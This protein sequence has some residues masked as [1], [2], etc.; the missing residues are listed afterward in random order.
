MGVGVGWHTGLMEA[1]LFRRVGLVGL[2]DAG[3]VSPGV[4]GWWVA[5]CMLTNPTQPTPKLRCFRAMRPSVCGPEWPPWLP[6]G[7]RDPQGSTVSRM[8]V[9]STQLTP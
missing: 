7:C 2:R 3:V 9:A 6:P 4:Q 8:L 1:H 5:S